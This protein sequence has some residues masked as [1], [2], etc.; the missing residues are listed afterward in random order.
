M[1][2]VSVFR[3]LV[4][5]SLEV[6]RHYLNRIYLAATTKIATPIQV[7]KVYSNVFLEGG[8]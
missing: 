2:R 8:F 7:V 6:V 4:S 5:P 1:T 3:E